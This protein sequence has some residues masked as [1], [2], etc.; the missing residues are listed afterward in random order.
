MIINVNSVDIINLSLNLQ[1]KKVDFMKR[2]NYKRKFISYIAIL[3]IFLSSFLLYTP[4]DIVLSA[5]G[6]PNIEVITPSE[7]SVFNNEIVDFTGRFSDDSTLPD[8]LSFSVFEKIDASSEPIEITGEGQLTVTVEGQNSNW[9][10]SKPFTEGSHSISFVLGSKKGKSAEK[11][12][13][14]TVNKKI[15][16]EQHTSIDETPVIVDEPAIPEAEVLPA[17][18][19][20][21]VEETGPRP[22]IVD[23]KIIPPGVTDENEYLAIEDMTQVPLDSKILMKIREIRLIILYSTINCFIKGWCSCK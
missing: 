4:A 17:E 5:P 10:F 9:T 14:F 20:S 15:V 6:D 12:I 1:K 11:T 18:E 13:N 21:I 2:V 19:E 8:Q 22:F 16:D 3:S 23:M 7:G